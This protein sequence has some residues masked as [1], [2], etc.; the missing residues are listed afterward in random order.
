MARS[1]MIILF[2][3]VVDVNLIGKVD[4]PFVISYDL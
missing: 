1:R 2:F 4:F 3:T